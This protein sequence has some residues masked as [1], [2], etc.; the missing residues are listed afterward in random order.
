MGRLAKSSRNQIWPVVKI[1]RHF[2]QGWG[3][4]SAA[5]KRPATYPGSLDSSVGLCP[6]MRS[7]RRVAAS[8]RLGKFY[9]LSCTKRFPDLAVAA[10]R[11]LVG[12]LHLFHLS[13]CLYS[14]VVTG[15]CLGNRLKNQSDHFLFHYGCLSSWLIC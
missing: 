14:F 5:R 7:S 1:T 6:T 12:Y 11:Q 4:G 8:T 13:D 15:I 2:R 3:S 9:V 10:D